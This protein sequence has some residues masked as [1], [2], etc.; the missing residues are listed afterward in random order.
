MHIINN[1]GFILL[2]IYLIL[3]GLS[4]VAGLAIP[5][6]ITGILALAAGIFILIGR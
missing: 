5:G 4:S 3:I 1:I 2:A 6:I